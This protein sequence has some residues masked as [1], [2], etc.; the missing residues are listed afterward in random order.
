MPS[1]GQPSDSWAFDPEDLRQR[2]GDDWELLEE[3]V[4]I[5][6]EDA[7][8]QLEALRAAVAAGDAAAIARGAHRLRG[9]ISSFAASHA[10]DIAARLESLAKIN[11]LAEAPAAI[12]ELDQAVQRL[13][14][15]LT[16]YLARG[17]W[18]GPEP[19]KPEARR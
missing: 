16:D 3:I 2:V 12:A 6:Q 15:N 4:P 19:V 17:R 11:H 8:R 7:P 10:T 14:T 13:T 18:P 1:S 5:F 9:A